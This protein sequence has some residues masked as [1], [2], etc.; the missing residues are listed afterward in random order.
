[1]DQIK[2]VLR[3]YF[4]KLY[5]DL[6]TKIDSME[7]LPLRQF[8][9]SISMLD[10]LCFLEAQFDI[11]IPEDEVIPEH[12]ENILSIIRFL[13]DKVMYPGINDNSK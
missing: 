1:M 4:E 10:L 6:A 2:D 5:P 8:V 3:N 12:F 11:A 13:E 9:D 7:L